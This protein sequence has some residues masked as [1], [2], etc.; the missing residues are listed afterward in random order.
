M[1]A[2]VALT[3]DLLVAA[4]LV[5]SLGK[6]VGIG[7]GSSIRTIVP[8]ELF[9][10]KSLAFLRAKVAWVRSTHFQSVWDRT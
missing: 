10:Y 7:R 9:T 2:N 3:L 6:T 4:S 5:R 8:R 1:L